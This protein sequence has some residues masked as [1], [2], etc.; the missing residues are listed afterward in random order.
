LRGH[1]NTQ[2]EEKAKLAGLWRDKGLVFTTGIGT[3]LCRQE[4]ITHSFKALLRKA[5]L[6]D[7]RFH[8]LKHSCTTLLLSK[9]VLAKFVQELL[10]HTAI[11]TTIRKYKKLWLSIPS[12]AGRWRR[13]ALDVIESLREGDV[14]RP[15]PVNR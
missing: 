9:G 11:S 5:S 10:D 1:C 7:I 12:L 14:V 15:F 2:L 8:D 6:P 3:P 4:L 13:R